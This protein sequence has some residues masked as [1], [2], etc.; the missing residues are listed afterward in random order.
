M[1]KLSF[2]E[3]E[4]L[5]RVLSLK[6]GYVLDFTNRA[7]SDFV[8]DAIGTDPYS[9]KYEKYGTS[10]AKLLRCLIEHEDES[11]VST[12]LLALLAREKKLPNLEVYP[13][14]TER[15]REDAENIALRLGGQPRT[16]LPDLTLADAHGVFRRIRIEVESCIRTKAYD[17]GLDRL[18]TF[19]T[20]YLRLLIVS[21]GG[22]TQ[23]Q[24]I[25]LHSLMGIYLKSLPHKEKQ[26]SE[27]TLRILRSTI[28]TL[29]S[30]NSV[31]NNHSLAHPTDQLIQKDEAEFIFTHIVALVG[32]LE[33]L[34]LADGQ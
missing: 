14:I 8:K 31:R 30:F 34:N 22:P 11:I 20:M 18:H 1:A 16:E 4:L 13:P 19:L 28:S 3:S 9:G 2:D 6:N 29:E 33:K 7:F 5:Q 25:P 32:L 10:K 17:T 23:S 24:D 15:E 26:V 27:M 21:T 12:L